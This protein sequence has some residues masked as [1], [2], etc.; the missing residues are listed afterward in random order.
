MCD[1]R[2]TSD[3]V[4]TGIYKERC[5]IYLN[6]F[7]LQGFD[8]SKYKFMSKTG[9]YNPLPMG[10]HKSSETR[11]SLPVTSLFLLHFNLLI[12]HS[13]QLR[14]ESKSALFS[15]INMENSLN[16]ALISASAN[17]IIQQIFNWKA[18]FNHRPLSRQYNI[19][20][21]VNRSV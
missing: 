8:I 20:T 16:F 4:I 14:T 18:T 7:I 11:N 17:N 5:F 15:H 13:P 2:L 1:S 21:M 10:I 12:I 3:M 9:F 19:D 6:C